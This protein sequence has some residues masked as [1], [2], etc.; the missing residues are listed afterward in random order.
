MMQG[1]S[2]EMIVL[3]SSII[4]SRINTIA[5][6]IPFLT[7]VII[8]PVWDFQRAGVNEIEKSC[9]GRFLS[10]M[11]KTAILGKPVLPR[12]ATL[13]NL[14]LHLSDHSVAQFHHQH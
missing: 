3:L 12:Q 2:A 8:C 5:V 13:Q 4:W 14:P 9:Q 6:A 1:G 11:G 10:H 7:H